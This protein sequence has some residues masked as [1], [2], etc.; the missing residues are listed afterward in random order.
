MRDDALLRL[1]ELTLRRWRRSDADA[2]A[3]AIEESVEHLRPWMPW[4]ADEPLS[5]AARRALLLQWSIDWRRGVNRNL[6]MWV[7]GTL[8]GA[9]GL[10]RRVGPDG[11]EIGY[12]VHPRHTRHGYATRAAAALTT[13]AFDVVDVD[14]VEIRNDHANELSARIPRRLGFELVGEIPHPPLAPGETGVRQLWRMDSR[15]WAANRAEA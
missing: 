11:L 3:R 6:G 2:L 1:G 12:W 13:Y 8:V 9:C 14:R 10:H 7:D 5:P 4:I 15:R